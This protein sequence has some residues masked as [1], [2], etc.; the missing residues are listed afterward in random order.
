MPSG[1]GPDGPYTPQ[2]V[3]DGGEEFVGSDRRARRRVHRDGCRASEAR[4]NGRT[5]RDRNSHVSVS[6]GVRPRRR[7]SSRWCMIPSLQRSRRRELRTTSDP[8]LG[9]EVAEPGGRNRA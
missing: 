7:S 6:G 9:G 2:M 8:H 4:G 5:R 1:F 3:V